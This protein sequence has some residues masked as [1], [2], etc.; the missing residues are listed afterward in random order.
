MDQADI[1]GIGVHNAHTADVL[2]IASKEIAVRFT[3]RI[4]ASGIPV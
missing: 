2:R 4:C 1:A 3:H